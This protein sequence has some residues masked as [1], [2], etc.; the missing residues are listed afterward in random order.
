MPESRQH[1]RI[2]NRIA[3]RDGVDYNSQKGPDVVRADRVTEVE[4]DPAKVKEGIGQISRFQRQRYIAG[5]KAVQKE[6]LEQTKGTGIGVRDANGNI[7]K[8]AR[9]PS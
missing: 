2:S 7:V 9:R 6:A 5:P 1:R 3:R 8:R 4:I